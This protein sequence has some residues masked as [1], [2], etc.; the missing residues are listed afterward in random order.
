[1]IELGGYDIS[2]CVHRWS[3]TGAV[4]EVY[5]AELDIVDGAG[6]VRIIEGPRM[7]KPGRTGQRGGRETIRV[8]TDDKVNV[9]GTDISSWVVGYD[10]IVRA[11]EADLVRLYL[12]ADRNVLK[13]NGTCPWVEAPAPDHV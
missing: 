6:P 9:G 11:R 10:R 1:M 4:G 13:I 3:V 12:H 2:D 8:A 7:T 5:R